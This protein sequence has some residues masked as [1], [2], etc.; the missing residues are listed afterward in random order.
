MNILIF[1]TFDKEVIWDKIM[2]KCI[3][4][5]LVSI[6]VPKNKRA[7]IKYFLL[8]IF[9]RLKVLKKAMFVGK[10]F[11]CGEN[12]VKVNKFTSIGNNVHINGMVIMGSGN[13]HIGNF[14]HF[15]AE[16]LILSDSHNYEGEKIPYD[17]TLITKDTIIE[18]FVW[19]GAR[20][21]ILP[22]ARIGEGAIIQAGS[23]VHG[24]IPPYAIAGGNPAKVFKYRNKEH[25]ILLKNNKKFLQ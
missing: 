13:V 9:N 8:G 23:V 24:I 21:T 17:N 16:L 22:G 10:H 6:L 7:E 5:L 14:C 20:V 19:C 4:N 3:I 25:F 2:Y 18:D 12:I 15:G 1:F 11:F